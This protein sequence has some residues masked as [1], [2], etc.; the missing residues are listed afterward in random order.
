MNLEDFAY[1]VETDKSVDD[2]V[3][4]VLREVEK[5]GWSVFNVIGISE[6]L[7]A[8]GFDQKPVK[9]VEICNGKH[10]NHF[11]NKDRYVSLF[12][13][14]RINIME[15]DGKVKIS[16]MRPSVMSQFFPNV[17]QSEAAA[18]EKDVIEI[19]DSAK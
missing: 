16:S 13:P 4:A 8:K 5:K 12:M 7:A 1:V 10:A 9:L 17:D 2:A 11:L 18:V 6:R 14:C 19:I 15:E 3:V